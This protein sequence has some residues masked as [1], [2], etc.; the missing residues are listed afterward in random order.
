MRETRPGMYFEEDFRQINA[1]QPRQHLL[2]QFDQAR[3]LL[4]FIETRDGECVSALYLF[5]TDRSIRRQ[6]SSRALIGGLEVLRERVEFRLR[7]LATA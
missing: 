2:A 1:W 4:Q 5:Y 6:V 7:R 3:W